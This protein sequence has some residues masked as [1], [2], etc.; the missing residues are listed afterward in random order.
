MHNEHSAIFLC[1]C[2]F[3]EVRF[4]YNKTAACRAVELK[5]D[6]P[7]AIKIAVNTAPGRRETMRDYMNNHPWSDVSIASLEDNQ[8]TE[9]DKMT[10]G[11]LVFVL[12]AIAEAAR[13]AGFLGDV[14]SDTHEPGCLVSWIQSFTQGREP[15]GRAG[16]MFDAD[17]VIR[18]WELESVSS[19]R[20][21]TG[22]SECGNYTVQTFR[23]EGSK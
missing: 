10:R 5:T 15:A 7:D 17:E 9:I 22:K 3:N 1:F 14:F 18:G 20:P 21:G 23:S 16:R 4:T 12:S 11:E 2:S 6:Q 19:E 8:D 13:D